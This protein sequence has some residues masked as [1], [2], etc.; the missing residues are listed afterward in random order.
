M[1]PTLKIPK[2]NWA[3][4]SWGQEIWTQLEWDWVWAEATPLTPLVLSTAVWVKF[5]TLY[6]Q[7]ENQA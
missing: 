6:D 7:P 3:Y 5:K 1:N 4:I 2:Q